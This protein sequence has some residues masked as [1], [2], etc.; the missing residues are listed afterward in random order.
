[1]FYFF[2]FVHDVQNSVDGVSGSLFFLLLC[3]FVVHVFFGV[4]KSAKIIIFAYAYLIIWGT[5]SVNFRI[6][7]NRNS[8]YSLFI[9]NHLIASKVK[10]MMF[11][12]KTDTQTCES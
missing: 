8:I 2:F 5:L 6:N 1:M 4:A 9:L 11:K 7:A 12:K 10:M 3:F